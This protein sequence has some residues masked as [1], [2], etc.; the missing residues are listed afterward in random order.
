MNIKRITIPLILFAAASS[1]F[2]A[3]YLRDVIIP[4]ADWNGEDAWLDATTLD[5]II[6]PPTSSDNVRVW[7]GITNITE[8]AVA[9]NISMQAGE[10]KTGEIPTLNVSANLTL[11]DSF[12]VE[13][14]NLNISA[15]TTTISGG[16]NAFGMN[17]GTLTLSGTSETKSN[18]F[19]F[20]DNGVANSGAITVNVSDSAKMTAT[21]LANGFGF[22][23]NARTQ[24]VVVNVSDNAAL[25]GRLKVGIGDNDKKYTYSAAATVNIS[26]NAT[27]SADYINLYRN[28]TLNVSGEAVVTASAD[29]RLGD[30]NHLNSASSA[31]QASVTFSDSSRLN[32]NGGENGVMIFNGATVTF[33]DNSVLNVNRNVW[34]GK[35]YQ[36]VF[37]SGHLILK[38]NVQTYSGANLVLLGA[39]STV[40]FYG[41]NIKA[42]SGQTYNFTNLGASAYRAQMAGTM[43]YIADADGISLIKINTIVAR[44]ESKNT[45]YD[46]LL[47]FTN[48]VLTEGETKQMAIIYSNSSQNVI[49]AYETYQSDLITVIKANEADTYSIYASGKTLY[50]DYTSAIIPEPATCAAM[51][52][53]L[54]LAFAAYRRRK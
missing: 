31:T 45:G 44:D 9:N 36:G 46:I 2:A 17:S 42:K 27:V 20:G 39:D 21:T 23:V 3:T 4:E 15:G 24:D 51:A 37:S 18:H 5:S 30:M 28:A 52:G 47:D 50:I 19:N 43:K 49:S 13:K 12:Y 48:F 53:L 41:S 10:D 7:F 54:A 29:A 26:G 40:E 14:G 33:E 34:V 35:T 38:D 25:T 32:V 22:G 8:T 16:T 11:A 1:A 6:I